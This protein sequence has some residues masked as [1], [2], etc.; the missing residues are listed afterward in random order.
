VL[1]HSRHQAP[2]ELWPRPRYPIRHT[3]RRP[4]EA[5]DVR[6]VDMKDRPYGEVATLARPRTA[7]ARDSETTIAK[8]D[9]PLFQK[10]KL[11]RTALPWTA[12]PW[13]A[14]PWR[15]MPTM[16]LLRTGGSRDAPFQFGPLIRQT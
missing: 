13:T 16:A 14:L 10:T 11:P 12:L 8:R 3:V 5:T 7:R 4:P 6:W 15:K 2:R 1:L 9:L